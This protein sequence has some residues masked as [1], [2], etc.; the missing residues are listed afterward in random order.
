MKQYEEELEHVKLVFK[1]LTDMGVAPTVYVH[2]QSFEFSTIMNVAEMFRS[3]EVITCESLQNII[4][5]CEYTKS[6]SGGDAVAQQFARTMLEKQQAELGEVS[7]FCDKAYLCGDNWMNVL[8][9]N[10]TLS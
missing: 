9:W 10:N 4:D 7:D 6:E 1:F 3:R 2:N 8:I 5:E